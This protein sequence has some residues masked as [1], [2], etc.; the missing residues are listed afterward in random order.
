MGNNNS[1]YLVPGSD[2]NAIGDAIRSKSGTA[3]NFT[4]K[5][6]VSA[7]RSI[8]TTGGGDN[9]DN[10]L[11]Y[12]Y[13]ETYNSFIHD[14]IT[15]PVGESRL[16]SFW[17][18]GAYGRVSS[19]RVHSVGYISPEVPSCE[20]INAADE[21]NNAGGVHVSRLAYLYLGPIPYG[22]E[23]EVYVTFSN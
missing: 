11:V 18:D 23:Y 14:A 20:F 15:I 9:T 5:E 10:C 8:P 12:F 6:M 17:Y 7:I 21:D 16:M 3:N 1:Y 13:D 22:D 2:L 4:I 19:V